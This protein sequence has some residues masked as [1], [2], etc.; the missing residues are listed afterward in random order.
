MKHSPSRSTDK[1]P[2]T[3]KF[4]S[5]LLLL[6]MLAFLPGCNKQLDTT[7]ATSLSDLTTFTEVR[8][9]LAGAYAQ[10]QS[11]NYLDCP[12][13]SGSSCG[14]SAIPDLMGD[15]FVEDLTSLGNWRFL[16]EMSYA[17]DAGQ[18]QGLFTG[19]YELISRANNVLQSLTPFLTGDSANEALQIKAQALALRAN[20]H[21]DLM[22]YFAQDFGRSSTNSGIPYVTRFNAQ[23]PFADLPS[24]LTV[25]EDYDSLFND[26]N[27][28]LDCYRQAGD[29]TDNVSRNYIDSIVLYA[30]RARVN[31][32]ASQWADA[33]DDASVVLDLSPLG[34]ASDYLYCYDQSSEA[35]PPSEVVWA[36]P[37]DNQLKP[38][39]AT[40]GSSPNYRVSTATSDQIQSLGGAYASDSIIAFDQASAGSFPSTLLQK[41]S[42]INSFKAF[43][44]GEMILI[45]AEAEAHLGSD[46]DALQDLNDLRTNRG[47]AVGA[48]TGPALMEAIFSIRR[49]ELLGDGHRWF[50]LKRTT[51]TIN[52]SDCGTAGG[53]PSTACSFGPDTRGWNFPIPLNDITANPRLVQNPGY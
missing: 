53:S 46:V 11:Q 8:N 16:S 7:P 6:T 47:V 41:Y 44:A 42:G 49:I 51:R 39:L 25:K 13:A 35:E 2:F 24:R 48:E 52:R 37:S 14:W 32:Y 45:R 12:G 33:I 3:Q 1:F 43:R 18:V 50:D 30:I 23:D 28:A 19:P 27:G 9:G 17:A 10:L 31:G 5:S 22:R 38:G 29:L 34:S 36:V 21:F 40:N 26:L 4:V 15:D 20:A